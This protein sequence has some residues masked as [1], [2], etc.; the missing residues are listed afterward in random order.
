MFSIVTGYELNAVHNPAELF[1]AC[2]QAGIPES[3]VMFGMASRLEDR[4]LC[5]WSEVEKRIPK[6]RKSRAVSKTISNRAPAG[7]I[8]QLANAYAA[9]PA[10]FNDRLNSDYSPLDD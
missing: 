5:L 6:A 9:I 1:D 10:A 4:V 3:E 8:L 7:R 2:R